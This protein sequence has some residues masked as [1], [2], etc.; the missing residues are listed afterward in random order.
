MTKKQKKQLAKRMAE[1][2]LVIQKNEDPYKVNKAKDEM[3]QLIESS[4]LELSEI[5]EI[6]LL[7]SEILSEK[8]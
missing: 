7:V 5:L 2:E 4:D 3:M 1:L 8:I 6:D